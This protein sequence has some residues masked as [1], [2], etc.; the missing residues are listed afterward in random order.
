MIAYS[1]NRKA[2]GERTRLVVELPARLVE[3]LDHWGVSSG[4]RS[5]REAVEV[6][7]D[8]KLKEKAAGAEFGDATPAA[9][10]AQQVNQQEAQ[11][12]AAE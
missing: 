12:H 7:L 8:E 4:K 11:H 9:G 2:K 6:L 3:N 10:K 1:L 5:R